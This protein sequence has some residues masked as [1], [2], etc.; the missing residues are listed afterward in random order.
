MIDRN[1][2]LGYIPP[3]IEP[4]EGPEVPAFSFKD[5]DFWAQGLNLG[6]ECHF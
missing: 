4:V 6:L 2:N 5:S 1:I 3:V